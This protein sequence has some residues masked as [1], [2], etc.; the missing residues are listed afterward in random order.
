MRACVCVYRGVQDE[1]CG[2]SELPVPALHG[3]G[4]CLVD[5]PRVLRRRGEFFFAQCAQRAQSVQ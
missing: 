5:V 4:F 2:M 1:L 3:L